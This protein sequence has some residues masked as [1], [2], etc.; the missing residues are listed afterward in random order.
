MTDTGEISTE[1]T[2]RDLLDVNGEKIGRVEDVRV[3]EATGGLKW[4]VVRTGLLGR[5]KVLVPAAEVRETKDALA[6]SFTK[7][8]VKDSP[9]VDENEAF[10]VEEERKICSYYGLEYVS[11]FA[12]PTEGCVDEKGEEGDVNRQAPDA[13]KQ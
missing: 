6:V 13:P 12:S 10:G 5:K 8:R 3:G 2:G 4:L 7:D 11:E 9:G 1:W